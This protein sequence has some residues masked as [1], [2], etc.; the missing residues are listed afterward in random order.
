MRA[1][2]VLCER[3]ACVSQ[4]S[5]ETATSVN[6][7]I[8][9]RSKPRLTKCD[10][11]RVP[12]RLNPWQRGELSLWKD[13]PRVGGPAAARRRGLPASPPSSLPSSSSAHQLHGVGGKGPCTLVLC[14]GEEWAR[15]SRPGPPALA[16][17]L[18]SRSGQARPWDSG[19]G[20][21]PLQA[22]LCLWDSVL[23][24]AA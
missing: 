20:F 3:I 23:G 12:A 6:S 10:P 14:P 8:F 19:G 21:Q 24:A 5:S 13:P 22:P 15:G 2:Q 11:H 7:P 18:P 1:C 17:C 4:P 16:T 9:Q